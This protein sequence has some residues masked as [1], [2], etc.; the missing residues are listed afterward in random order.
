[1]YSSTCN[2]APINQVPGQTVLQAGLHEHTLRM[3]HPVQGNPKVRQ[4]LL[5]C[6]SHVFMDRGLLQFA[7]LHHTC[8]AQC[9]SLSRQR[10]TPPSIGLTRCSEY[11]GAVDRHDR[12]SITHAGRQCVMITVSAPQPLLNGAHLKLKL[13]SASAKLTHITTNSLYKKG[14]L[15]HMSML[16]RVH[17]TWYF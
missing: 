8:V 3:Q 2:S 1:M 13:V 6:L 11:H 7:S 17:G 14:T 9:H 10:Q 16:I 15:Q 12:Q 5:L 4:T